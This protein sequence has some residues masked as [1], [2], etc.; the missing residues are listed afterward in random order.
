MNLNVLTLDND[1]TIYNLIKGSSLIP[2]ECVYFLDTKKGIDSFI[3]NND[4]HVLI[5]EAEPDPLDEASFLQEIKAFDSLLDVIL[6]GKPMNQVEM[7]DMVRKGATDYLTRPLK[8]QDLE[9][10]LKKIKNKRALRKKTFQ[11]ETKLENKYSFHGMVGKNPFMLEMFALIEKTAPH[12]SNALITGE[13]GVGKK[14]AAQVLQRLSP[15]AKKKLVVFNCISM[16][17]G[18]FEP[19]LFGYKKNYFKGAKK[20]QKGFLEIADKGVLYL[21]EISKMPLN[22]QAKLA[23]FLEEG[24]VRP[25]GGVDE[26]K[27]DVKVIAS[28]TAD[29]REMVQNNGFMKLL[30]QGLNELEIFI[31]PLR[32]RTEDIPLLV[33]HFLRRLKKKHRKNVKG[34]SRNAQKFFQLYEW[35]GNVRELEDVLEQAVETSKKEYI[36]IS[37]L[38]PYF[39]EAMEK[40]KKI[41]FLRRKDLPTLNELE[42]EYILYLLKVTDNHMSK[43]AKIM[44]ISR[45]TLY[46]KI[47]RYRIPH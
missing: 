25:L 12:F 46:N 29:L 14:L 8:K 44:G 40:P 11:L 19:E 43:T 7:L 33:R 15:I 16:P 42:K 31:P 9:E 37:D 28:S 1:L 41:P 21:D 10:T 6:V 32:K 36:D 18:L 3:R 45:S 35:P 5:K 27:V 30:Y 24:V 39:Q 2:D 17:V 20:D 26:K 34:I 13:P 4:I 38:P 22:F 47:R 23:L